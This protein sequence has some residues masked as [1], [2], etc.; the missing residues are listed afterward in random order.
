M[1]Y[2]CFLR[3]NGEFYDI[4]LLS[5][6]SR[7]SVRKATQTNI[8]LLWGVLSTGNHLLWL[9]KAQAYTSRKKRRKEKKEKKSAVKKKSK[10]GRYI[11]NPNT[12]RFWRFVHFVILGCEL[13]FFLPFP[14]TTMRLY[15]KRYA[16]PGCTVRNGRSPYHSTVHVFSVLLSE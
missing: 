13:S 1:Y 12:S 5:H 9:H 16:V 4:T 3:E 11:F 8:F 14:V 2:N 6:Q 7:T 15:S 10:I